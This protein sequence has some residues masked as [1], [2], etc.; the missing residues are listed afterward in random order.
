MILLSI[1][2]SDPRRRARANM[3][4]SSS[5]SDVHSLSPPEPNQRDVV[6]RSVSA[7]SDHALSVGAKS[8]ALPMWARSGIHL[9]RWRRRIRVVCSEEA[10]RAET[11]FSDSIETEKGGHE[12]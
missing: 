5:S 7:Q 8:V 6:A 3:T 9:D 12:Q 4:L 1:S 2:S 10:D 11:M